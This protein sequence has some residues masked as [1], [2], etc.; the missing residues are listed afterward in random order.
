VNA[1]ITNADAAIN[2]LFIP[3]PANE[4]SLSTVVLGNGSVSI[5]PQQSYYVPGAVVTLTATPNAPTVPFYGWMGGDNSTN[6]TTTVTMTTNLIVY[7][8]FSALPPPSPAAAVA[9]INGGV[10]SSVAVTRAGSGYT[11]LPVVTIL[12]GGGNGAT[13]TAVVQ[14]GV[15]V[16]VNIVN[17]GSGYTNVPQIII[18]PP[19]TL[20]PQVGIV[21]ASCLTFSNLTDSG[22]YLLQ[23][24]VNQT[25]ENLL[26]GITATN[27]NM[28]LWV[29]GSAVPNSYRLVATPLPTTAT[30]IAITSHGFVVSATVTSG[31]SG[32][33]IAPGVTILGGGGSGATASAT[34]SNGAVTNLTIVSAGSGYTNAPTITIAD[35]PLVGGF[36]SIQPGIMLEMNNLMTNQ[37]YQLQYATQLNGSWEALDNGDFISVSNN[38]SEYRLTT[39]ATGYFRIQYVP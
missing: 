28:T 4:F 36:A 12:G 27:A 38:L 31:G 10:C 1:I 21:R 25:W 15:V 2:A 9:I 34:V 29:N 17:G 20:T 26:A 37:I 8:N 19:L 35:P 11:N 6:S 22:V 39:N 33:A 13:A 16:A 14:N 18:E 7:A 5:S 3:L 23:D 24:Q 30:A 32:Y